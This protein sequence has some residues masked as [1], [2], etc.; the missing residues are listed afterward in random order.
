[1]NT[2]QKMQKFD[3]MRPILRSLL[4]KAVR[5]GNEALTEKVAF[6][7]ANNGDSFWVRTRSSVITF[8]EC[9]P[10]S[11]SLMLKRPPIGLLKEVANSEKQKDAAGLGSLAYAAFDGDFSAVEK[12]YDP[13]AVRYM[14][15]ALKRPSSFFKWAKSECQSDD[16]LKLVLSAEYFISHATWPWDKAFVLSSAFLGC[17]NEIP[18]INQSNVLVPSSFPYWI[19]VDKHTPQGK[20]AINQ[21]ALK[22][23][24]SF[25]VLQW[26]SFYFESAKVQEMAESNWWNSDLTWRFSSL[27]FSMEEA[28]ALW[29]KAAPLVE[30]A[31]NDDVN[32]IKNL[33]EM[34]DGEFF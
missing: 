27:G 23:R 18:R 2:S 16:Q 34:S 12:A 11:R 1:M 19:A 5:R 30:N 31:V 32:K 20:K 13:L 29:E 7:L 4:Q 22:L 14:V 24:V 10:M 9:W 21:V 3:L 6:I 33:I 26:V 15:A 25:N 28:K 8:E 17:Q